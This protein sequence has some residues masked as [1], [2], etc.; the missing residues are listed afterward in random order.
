MDPF[1]ISERLTV[2]K[3]HVGNEFNQMNPFPV[4]EGGGL[5]RVLET[6]LLVNYEDNPKPSPLHETRNQTK[7][8]K[9]PKLIYVIHIL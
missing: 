5:G 9:N 7:T 2:K 6:E 3:V 8:K 4:S 1:H